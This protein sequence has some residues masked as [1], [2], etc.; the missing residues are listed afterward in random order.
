M[1]KTRRKQ[2]RQRKEDEAEDID[3]HPIGN[4]SRK[5]PPTDQKDYENNSNNGKRKRKK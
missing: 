1:R 4:T 5:Y 3:W 2:K